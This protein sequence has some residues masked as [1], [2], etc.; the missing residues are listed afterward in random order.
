M[1]NINLL[2][3][4]LM[5]IMA[6][7]NEEFKRMVIDDG[8]ASEEAEVHYHINCPYFNGDARAS[9]HN[10]ENDINR[11]LCVDCK[12]KWLLQEVDK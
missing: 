6:F 7:E 5:D 4:A 11:E 12:R 1:K 8:G 10:R 2:I 9:C 3:N